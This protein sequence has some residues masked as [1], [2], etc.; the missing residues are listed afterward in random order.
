MAKHVWQCES[1]KETHHSQN[2]IWLCPGCEKETC[3]ACFDYYAH[4]KACSEGKTAAELL[5]LANE[6]GFDFDPTLEAM[7]TERTDG[8][9]G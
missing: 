5:R 2:Y 1:C 4:C 6:K 8:N 7:T 3:E 9:Q